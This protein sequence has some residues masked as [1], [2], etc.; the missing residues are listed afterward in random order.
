MLVCQQVNSWNQ[1]R[2][3]FISYV[4]SKRRKGETR[5]ETYVTWT[6]YGIQETL[7]SHVKQTKET[8]RFHI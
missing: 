6:N 8:Q 3:Y 4:I 5:H 1:M 7:T 2:I